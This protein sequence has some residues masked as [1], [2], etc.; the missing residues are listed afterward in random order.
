MIAGRRRVAALGWAGLA[1]ILAVFGGLMG[2]DLIVSRDRAIAEIHRDQQNLAKVIE[3]QI[4]TSV[5]RIDIVLSLLAG[6]Y[7]PQLA[8]PQRPPQV[9]AGD[10]LLHCLSILPEVELDT[11][12]VVD[13]DGRIVFG[14]GTGR[15]DPEAGQRIRAL[16][17]GRA[18][19]L[20]ISAPDQSPGSGRW[21]VALSRPVTG[22]D[23]TLLGLVEVG[24]PA[25]HYERL[26]ASLDVGHLGSVALFDREFRLLARHP[27]PP[28][29][30]SRPLTLSLITP[31][32]AAGRAEGTFERVSAIDGIYRLFS[33]RTVDGLPFVL[34]L[35]RSPDE[36]LQSWRG[37]AALYAL[38]F[39]GLAASLAGLL[40]LALRHTERTRRLINQV[41][42]TTRVSILVTD[43]DDRLVIANEGFAA[44]WGFDPAELIGRPVAALRS[45][46]HDDAFYDQIRLCLLKTG[47]WSGELWGRRRSGEDFP[48]MQSINTIRDRAGRVTHYISVSTDISELHQ[49][50]RRIEKQR[51]DLEEAQR[52]AGLGTW[53]YDLRTATL[54]WS[55]TSFTIFGRDRDRFTPTMDAFVASI[56]PEDRPIYDESTKLFEVAGAG[57]LQVRIL[58]PDGEVRH[59]LSRALLESD[60]TGA[61]RRMSGITLDVTEREQTIARLDLF[62]RIADHTEQGVAIADPDGRILF[63]NPAFTRLLG[64]TAETLIGRS[65]VDFFADPSSPATL[66]L[67]RAYVEGRSWSGVVDVLRTDGSSLSILNTAGV[68]I[69]RRGRIQ[70]LFCIFSDYTAERERQ[71][72][73]AAARDAALQA[74]QAK[75]TFLATMSHELR[76]PL[77]A[78]LGFSEV[79]D[80]DPTLSDAHRESVHTIHMA[81][82]H[83]LDLINEI[84]DLARVESGHVELMIEP[85]AL[86]ALVAECLDLIAPLAR[87]RAVHLDP[88]SIPAGLAVQADRRRLK[89]A[90]VNLLS[91]AVKYNRREG[92][93]S[94]TAGQS[95]PGRVRLDVADTGPGIA[96]ERLGDLFV[97]FN[98]L[99]AE[100][101][102]IEGTGIGLALTRRIVEAMKGE[103]EIDSTL[104]RGSVFSITVPDATFPRRGSEGVGPGPNST[105]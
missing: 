79:L 50:R 72:E 102:G 42:R 1:A 77:N 94:V 37:T 88:P 45:P 5:G 74:S 33:Y 86:D 26:F 31:Q 46:V 54:W 10:D 9:T 40:F 76:T 70:Y 85:V 30:L 18:G 20:L 21:L 82:Y 78:I 99:G 57:Q 52:L 41:F 23:G 96:P 48:L 58:R 34:V 36:I 93:I 49:A 7:A 11:L 29:R 38:S 66:D 16:A 105:S 97:P 47:A 4:R 22:P 103:V 56:H 63:V 81:G 12:R 53:E 75:S 64:H 89:Q 39:T 55:D 6:A 69:D 98:R 17:A 61:P 51:R 35:G 104:G 27:A 84:L 13:R 100:L 2:L 59:I 8:G 14:V 68:V 15:I 62:G 32:L 95:A 87:D 92:R 73:L 80:M 67:M 3:E 83:L 19:S 25:D 28:D 43:R 101:S 44:L 60:A 71:R 24:I 65:F 91:N 90:L